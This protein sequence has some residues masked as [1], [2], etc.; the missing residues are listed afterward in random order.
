MQ[1][2]DIYDTAVNLLDTL[3][4]VYQESPEVLPLPSRQFVVVGPNGSH[5]HD[6]EQV[7]V[8]VANYYPGVPGNQEWMI[9]TCQGIHSAEMFVELVRETK[10]PET[11]ITRGVALS[12]AFKTSEQESALARD[13][14]RDLQLLFEAGERVSK[15]L[16]TSSRMSVAGSESGGYQSTTL[17]ITLQV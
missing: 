4:V 3:N 6:C 8:Y 14:L 10:Y 9:Q 5:P 16:L 15:T 11:T 2:D 17:Q 1:L 13:Q 12:T 7:V